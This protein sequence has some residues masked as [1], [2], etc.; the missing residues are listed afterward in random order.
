MKLD[1]QSIGYIERVV[2]AGRLV[3][4]DNVII[5]PDCVRAIDEDKTVVIHHTDNVPALEFGSIG[6]NRIDIL[7]SRLELV[8]NL[9]NFEVDAVV[10]ETKASPFT[11]SLGMKGKGTKVDY[12]CANP[13]TVQAPR[14]IN[15]TI[16]FGIEFNSIIVDFLTKGQR[17]MGASVVAFIADERGCTLQ[18]SDINNDVFEHTFA[19][20]VHDLDNEEDSQPRFIHR[21]PLNII[22]PLFKHESSVAFGIGQKGMLKITVDGFDFYVLPR[23]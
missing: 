12:R 23:A 21:Y 10:D 15:D 19:D 4:I 2:K 18:L 1:K 11:R 8:K 22:I 14:K 7:L 17:A 16:Q 6:L 20:K 3:G 9:D 13:A 5:E